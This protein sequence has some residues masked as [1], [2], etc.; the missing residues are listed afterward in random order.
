MSKRKFEYKKLI[1]KN[2]N[3][4][5]PEDQIKY[6]RNNSLSAQIMALETPYHFSPFLN[7]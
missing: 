3:A 6:R 7:D 2:K 1:L 4:K 5:I